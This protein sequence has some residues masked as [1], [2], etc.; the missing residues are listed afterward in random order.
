[1]TRGSF[2]GALFLIA[3][4]AILRY[5]VTAELAGIDLATVGLIL[6][7]A[8]GVMFVLALVFILSARPARNAPPP[9]Y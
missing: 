5:A 7:I 3:L 9:P 8:G 2:G 6:M 4:G 1:M